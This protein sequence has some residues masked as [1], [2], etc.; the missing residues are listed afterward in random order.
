MSK[1]REFVPK[2]RVSK[3][4]NYYA[5]YDRIVKAI[6]TRDKTKMNQ[7]E[8]ALQEAK[9]KKLFEK[10]DDA[11]IEELFKPFANGKGMMVFDLD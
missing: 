4:V 8:L 9:D 1:K 10:L 11:R 2:S 3:L 5:I 7:E 6:P